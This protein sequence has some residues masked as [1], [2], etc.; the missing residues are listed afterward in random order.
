M[1]GGPAVPLRLG[2]TV[3]RWW[4]HSRRGTPPRQ[5][6]GVTTARAAA[7]GASRVG[8][9]ADSDCVTG[10]GVSTADTLAG[11]GGAAGAPALRPEP[12]EEEDRRG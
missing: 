10:V 9:G 5:G 2:R 7:G 1:L 11:D 3:Y 4:P 12:G 6:I 8:A